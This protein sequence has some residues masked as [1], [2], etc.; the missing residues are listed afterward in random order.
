MSILVH[1]HPI[2]KH[3]IGQPI[4]PL[5]QITIFCM[6]ASLEVL[7]TRVLLMIVEKIMNK[8]KWHAITMLDFNQQLQVGTKN[9]ISKDIL[10]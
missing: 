3:A 8:V 2:L 9:R 4:I 7:M 10:D 5:I 1:A 6:A